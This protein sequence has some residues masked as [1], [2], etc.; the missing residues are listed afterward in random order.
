MDASQQ[1]SGARSPVE[2]PRY[3]RPGRRSA[4]PLRSGQLVIPYFLQ[5]ASVLLLPTL[6][7]PGLNMIL[8]PVMFAATG[9]AFLTLGRGGLRRRPV[10]M[11]LG[12]LDLAA[13]AGTV[14]LIGYLHYGS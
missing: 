13:V 5:I 10:L 12:L 6:A 9:I 2:V 11:L 14:A 3:R 8:A 7:Y 1:A 4:P